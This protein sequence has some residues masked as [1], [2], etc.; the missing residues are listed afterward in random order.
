MDRPSTSHFLSHAV[1]LFLG[2][3]IR[4]PGYTAFLVA[5]LYPHAAQDRTKTD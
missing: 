1:Y 3:R 4:V 5:I 2:F